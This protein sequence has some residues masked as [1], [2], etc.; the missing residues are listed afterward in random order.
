MTKELRVL[1]VPG[2]TTTIVAVDRSR[3]VL[4]ARLPASPWHAR[5]LP[6]LLKAL[7]CWYPLPVRAALVVD[8]RAPSCA[9]SLYPN[10]FADLGGD[11]YVLEVVG[12]PRTGER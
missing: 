3:V 7:A 12:R 10:W 8:E 4:R 1:V 9:T 5:A 6:R 11:A 2:R